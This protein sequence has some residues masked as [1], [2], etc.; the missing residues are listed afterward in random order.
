M[1]GPRYPLQ[2]LLGFRLAEWRR[3]YARVELPLDA[4]LE[5]RQGLPHGGV[6]ATL[7]DSAMGYSGCFSE[8]PDSPVLALTLS[9]TVNFLSRPRGGVLIAEG[10][11]RGGGRSTYFA[12]GR[13]RDDTGAAIASGSGVFRYRG[14]GGS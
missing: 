14:A 12:E 8:D 11:R 3:D 5:N 6:H 1:T 2:E 4:R 9:L 7:L 10:W 13:V